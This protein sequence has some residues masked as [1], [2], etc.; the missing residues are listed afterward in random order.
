MALI[1]DCPTIMVHAGKCYNHDKLNTADGSPMTAL[2]MMALKLRIADFKFANNFIICDRLPDMEILLGIDIQKKFPCHMHEI[3]K[4]TVTYR[5]TVDFSPTPE[6]VNR[7]QL[8]GLSSQLSKYHLDT[9]ESF[10]SGSKDKQLK[11]IWHTI[12]AFRIQQRG[13]IPT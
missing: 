9:V 3:M 6:A 1:M 13:N 12:S 11:D 10:Q 5:R 7:R 4:R 8:L 2:G